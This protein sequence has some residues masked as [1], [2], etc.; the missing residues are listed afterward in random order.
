[1]QQALGT[2]CPGG[3][4]VPTQQ[5]Y[6][7]VLDAAGYDQLRGSLLKKARAT[8]NQLDERGAARYPMSMLQET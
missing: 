8:W 5:V 6:G 4:H 7:N 1:M 2:T 3:L